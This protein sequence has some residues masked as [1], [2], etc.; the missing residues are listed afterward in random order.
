M[1]SFARFGIGALLTATVAFSAVAPAAAEGYHGGG[2]DRG[3]GG[4]HGHHEGRGGFGI[5]DFLLGAALV[6]GIA[7][8][9]SSASASHTRGY[10]ARYA[11]NDG[12]APQGA[13]GDAYGG[14]YSSEGYADGNASGVASDA[15]EQCSRAAERAAQNDGGYASVTRIDR[16]QPYR[17][18]ARVFGT[19]RIDYQAQ[20]YAPRSDHTRFDCTAGDGRVT[21]LR[22][23]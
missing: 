2:Y 9:A 23:G 3:Y 10:D 8:I 4:Y 17:D 5:G 7:A 12:Y 13:Y 18:G 1:R 14:G 15:V 22:L 11:P 21:G 16:V 19:L 6:G 20:G